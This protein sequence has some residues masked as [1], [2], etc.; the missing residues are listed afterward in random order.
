MRL[1]NEDAEDYSLNNKIRLSKA[2]LRVLNSQ[3][4]IPTK[5]MCLKAY[6]E[7]VDRQLERVI[8]LTNRIEIN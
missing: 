6:N 5:P 8:E 3:S 2:Y 4:L 1:H 7:A